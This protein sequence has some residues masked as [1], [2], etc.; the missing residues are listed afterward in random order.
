MNANVYFLDLAVHVFGLSS[1]TGAVCD[2]MFDIQDAQVACRS[3][4]YQAAESLVVGGAGA[5]N[6]PS[7]GSWVPGMMILMDDMQCV[8]NE[9]SLEWRA[10]VIRQ[11]L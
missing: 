5:S 2:D 6:R 1:C 10:T 11:R 9:S 7:G 8:G 3:L 4:G